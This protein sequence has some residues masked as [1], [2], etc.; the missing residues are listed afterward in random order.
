MQRF[1]FTSSYSSPLFAIA[2]AAA[3]AAAAV[4]AAVLLLLCLLL[5]AAAA[6]AL[7]W[8]NLCRW[9]TVLCLS[10]IASFMTAFA[11]STSSSHFQHQPS[12]ASV[13]A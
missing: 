12:P 3:A 5:I 4:A 13:L 1:C 7:P 2:A 11:A 10:C 9:C 6:I 8:D